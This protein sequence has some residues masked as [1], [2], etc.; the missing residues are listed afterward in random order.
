MNFAKFQLTRET[1][2]IGTIKGHDEDGRPLIYVGGHEFVDGRCTVTAADFHLAP[3][4]A[5]IVLR[6]HRARLIEKNF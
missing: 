5:V 1:I 3:A 4:N 6:H 2:G